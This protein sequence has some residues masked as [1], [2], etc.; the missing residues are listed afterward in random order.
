MPPVKHTVPA[1][2]ARLRAV[3]LFVLL[4][5]GSRAS[6]QAPRWQWAVSPSSGGGQG[7]A[8]AVDA[9][10]NVYVTGTFTGTATFGATTLTSA[11][12][13]DVFVARLTSAGTSAWAVRAGGSGT[14]VGTGMTV[15]SSGVV[16][17]GSFASSTATFGAT[18]LVNA[19][20]AGSLDAFVTR[21]TP[22]GAWSWA[23]GAGGPGADAAYGVAALNGGAVIVVGGYF[24]A[25]AAA[26][27]A[28]SLTSAGGADAF[29]GYLSNIGGWQRT[30]AVGGSGNEYGAGVATDSAGRVTFAGS[31]TSPTLAL[32]AT[33]LTNAGAATSDVFVAQLAPGGTWSWAASGGGSGTEYCGGVAVDTTGPVALTGSYASATAAFGSTTLTNA[34]A[35]GTSGDDVFVARLTPA[36]AWLWAVGAGTSAPGPAPA[37]GRAVAVDATGGVVVAGSFTGTVAFPPFSLNSRGLFDAFVAKLSAAGTWQ[38]AASVGGNNYEFSSSVAVD[39]RGGV[40]VTGG[41]GSATVL[42]GAQPLTN[43][44]VNV[45]AI[46]VGR[47]ALVTGLAE[48][49]AV[50]AFTLAPNP[51]HHTV[52]LSGLPAGTV[53]TLRDALGRTVRTAPAPAGT[54]ALDVRGLPAGLYFVQAGGAG[55]RLVVE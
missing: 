51:A 40:A 23:V 47:L 34:G 17:V 49:A 3:F 28:T 20:A 36:G 25:P 24:S 8:T 43:P 5:A 38:W 19:G 50:P 52:A 13:E 42:F 48:N 41:F 7:N 16:V 39:G 33:T 44:N 2:Y 9:A 32:G 37:F 35:I 53:I 21:L 1:F 54:A 31:F 30:L 12:A 6:A 27:G 4:L 55:R 29:V 26:F 18:T 14:D 15:D 10:G 11:G 45:Y 46:F 22:A